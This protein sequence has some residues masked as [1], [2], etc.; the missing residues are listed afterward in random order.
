M[1][2]NNPQTTFSKPFSGTFRLTGRVVD[3][4]QHGTPYLK[5][6]L[7][8]CN[9]DHIGGF[10]VESTHFPEEIGYLDQVVVSGYFCPPNPISLDVKINNIRRAS[11]EEAVSQPV[12]N[13]L[14]KVYCP[15]QKSFE[16]MVQSVRSL[17]SQHL[18]EFVRRVIERKDRMEAFLNAPASRAHHHAYPGGLLEHS[19]DVAKN[20]VAMAQINEPEMPRTLKE[21]GFVAGL[22]H[23]IGKTYTYDSKGKPNSAWHLCSH[24][25]LTLEACAFGLAYLDRHA[26]ELAVTLRHIW[27]SASPGARYGHQPATT[28]AR[29][30]RDA[31]G[32]SAMSDRQSSIF[33]ISGSGL[34]KKGKGVF[35]SPAV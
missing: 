7:S 9:T 1:M 21:L 27:T 29:Y 34:I 4:D 30:V 23:D 35:W 24:D 8:N 22:F 13:S 25:A 3:F 5:I 33:Q 11:F 6:R 12:L 17:R 2:L 28:L 20:V 19:L 31:D 18:Q 15:T 32:Q 14:P 10:D 26:P 16:K